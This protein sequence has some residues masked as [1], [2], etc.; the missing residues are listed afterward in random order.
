MNRRCLQVFD[1]SGE[2]GCP[3][4]FVF[5]VDRGSVPFMDKYS[6]KKNLPILEF[7]DGFSGIE[8]ARD[9]GIG[10]YVWNDFAVYVL[11]AEESE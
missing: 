9:T 2:S 10:E 11:V 3:F 4:V 1:E 8:H 7:A 6:A 5:W